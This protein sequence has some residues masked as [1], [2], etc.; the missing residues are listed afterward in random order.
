MINRVLQQY[1][2][3]FCLDR[4]NDWYRFLAWA[5]FSYN[6]SFH[7]GLQTT[8][9]QA[10]YGR[11]PPTI[12]MYIRGQSKLD[13]VDNDLATRDELLAS[14]RANL[15]KAQ[16]RMKIQANKH[17]VDLQLKEGDFVYAKL[18]PY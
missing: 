6:S 9:F 7:E 18:Q 17:R 1:L 8:P 5:E 12:P 16:Q 3:C 4:P 11:A 2:R 15:F 14:F 10:V 13:A